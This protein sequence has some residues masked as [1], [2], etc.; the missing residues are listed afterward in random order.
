[1][2]QIEFVAPAGYAFSVALRNPNSGYASLATGLPVTEVTPG[3]YRCATG[4]VTGIVYVSA[5]A[6]ALRVVGYANLSAPGTNGYS[7]VLDTLA[8][9]DVGTVNAADIASD[10]YSKLAGGRSTL[11]SGPTSAGGPIDQVKTVDLSY[12]VPLTLPSTSELLWFMRCHPEATNAYLIASKTVGLTQLLSNTSPTANLASITRNANNV[13]ILI[14]AAA[15]SQLPSE[16]V[17]CELRERTQA[18]DEISRHEVEI[19]LR[20]SAGRN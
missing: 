4:A 6:G 9:A 3:V 11:L 16:T 13:A 1:M 17:A 10:V 8:G 15:L 2:S 7:E 5:V 12:T 14:K 18:G 20:H 19:T